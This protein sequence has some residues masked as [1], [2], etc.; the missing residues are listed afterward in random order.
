MKASQMIGKLRD[1]IYEHGDL[2]VCAIVEEWTDDVHAITTTF[3][4]ELTVKEHLIVLQ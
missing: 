1:I 4:N 2:D 3:I